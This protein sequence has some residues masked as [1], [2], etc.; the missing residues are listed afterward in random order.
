MI[1]SDQQV[2]GIGVGQLLHQADKLGQCLF[3]RSKYPFLGISRVASLIDQ[4]VVDVNHIVIT[5]QRSR[6]RLVHSQQVLSQ[7]NSRTR[8]RSSKDLAA[9][10]RALSALTIHYCI[11]AIVFSQLQC[12]VR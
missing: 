12:L 3:C 6:I 5:Q 4:V 1:C 11:A 7:N 9:I 8:H 10:S 2:A